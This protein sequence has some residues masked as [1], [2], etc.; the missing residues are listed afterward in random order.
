MKVHIIFLLKQT[1][2]SE[3][4]LAVVYKNQM[5]YECRAHD[6]VIPGLVPI[7]GM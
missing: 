3:M 2:T 6:V 4:N 1:Q 7:M 5:S